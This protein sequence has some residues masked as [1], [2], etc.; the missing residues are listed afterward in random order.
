VSSQKHRLVFVHGPWQLIMASAGLRQT[1]ANGRSDKSRDILIFFP[2]PDGPL[3]APIRQVMNQIAARVWPWHQVIMLDESINYVLDDVSECIKFLRAQTG[4]DHV[5]EIW[6][7][8]LWGPPEKIAVEAYP[9]SKVVLYEDGLQIYLPIED[10]YLTLS[11][12]LREPKKAYDSLKHRVRELRKPSNLAV[13]PLLSRHLARVTASYLWINQMVPAAGYQT[14]LPWV[15]LETRHVR[16][17]IDEISSLVMGNIEPKERNGRPRA[18]VLGQCFSNYGD[19]ERHVELSWY[20]D[21]LQRLRR[22][23]YDLIWKEHP[24]TRQPFL[25]E[26]TEA[27]EGVESS[28]DMGPWPVELFVK[29]LRVS[30]CAS[31]TSTSLFSI[32]LLFGLPSYS[33]A[34]RYISS[35]RFPN[36]VLTRL[37]AGSI[38]SMDLENPT[39]PPS[40]EKVVITTATPLFQQSTDKPGRGEQTVAEVG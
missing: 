25:P 16:A 20:V 7:D 26:L 34:G 2:L 5:D 3:S 10:N 33:T 14:R 8:C 15:Q 23:G 39:T 32:P 17:V 27:V 40:S 31:L 37:V 22:M 4:L 18:I 30:A 24:R 35:L 21:L 28:P 13:S 19:F 11:R 29:R 1:G 38:N 9:K 12:W 36:D 6:L